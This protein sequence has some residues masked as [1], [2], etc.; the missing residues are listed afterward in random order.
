MKSILKRVIPVLLAVV[1]CLQ[2]SGM[3]ANGVAA[4]IYSDPY[5]QQIVYHAEGLSL[6]I[7]GQA[8]EYVAVDDTAMSA[9]KSLN[10][11]TFVVNF[12]PMRVD[13]VQTLIGFSNGTLGYPNS[14]VHLYFKNDR[15]GF[16]I[17]QQQGGDYEKTYA[18]TNIAVGSQ[19]CTAMSA[20]PEYGYRI[21]LDGN[22]IL[23]CPL[24]EITSSLGY[25][26][27]G[28]IDGIDSGYVGKTKRTFSGAVNEYG[29]TGEIHSV[30]V[31]SVAL[32][33]DYLLE[34][35]APEESGLIYEASNLSFP[36]ES[37]D[38]AIDS[39][40]VTEKFASMD[41][42]TFI[43]AFTPQS[44]SVVQSLISFSDP[45]TAN[46]HFHIYV[47]TTAP[48]SGKNPD[49]NLLGFEIRRQS[50]G[51]ILKA[52]TPVEVTIGEQHIMA[53]TADPI[54]GYKL[55]FDGVCVYHML[56]G[57]AGLAYGFLSDIPNIS[58]GH[59]GGTER[60]YAKKYPYVGEIDSVQVYD[61]VLSDE[62]LLSIT[63]EAPVDAGIVRKMH[64]FNFGDWNS[65]G[66]RSCTNRGKSSIMKE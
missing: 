34:K 55:F 25:G 24:S 45:S 7:G 27:I 13:T 8:G 51:D 20:D 35:T 3:I 43:V 26:F 50:G 63:A 17:R 39:T 62:E 49:R 41:R 29:F 10:Q 6:P 32:P 1:L 31:Y 52:N 42:G 59:I 30:D 60:S 21:F 44:T 38:V 22:C 47:N 56:V 9:I 37:A 48:V 15:I 64:L 11:G 18:L 54:E 19:H 61:Y 16:E 58:V 36:N 2:S 40:L 5:D 33:K 53:M 46:S 12:T 4:D 65:P 14:Y 23:E 66:L 28:D 57:F